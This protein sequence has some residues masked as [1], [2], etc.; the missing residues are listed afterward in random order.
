VSFGCLGEQGFL[1]EDF[2]T[3]PDAALNWAISSTSTSM[4]FT[5]MGTGATS[6]STVLQA[7]MVS[8]GL[9]V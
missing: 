6:T 8:F 7:N 2:S 1:D 5:T 4:S 3:F 9:R